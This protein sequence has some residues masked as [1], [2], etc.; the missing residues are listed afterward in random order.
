[1]ITVITKTVRDKMGSFD[2]VDLDEIRDEC[3]GSVAEGGE[4]GWVK[5]GG[6]GQYSADEL[7]GKS[8]K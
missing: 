7:K 6:G 5:G 4:G 8:V 3:E 2:W 1:M